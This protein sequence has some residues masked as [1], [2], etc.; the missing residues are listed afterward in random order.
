MDGFHFACSDAE[1]I[2]AQTLM[3][4]IRQHN[5]IKHVFKDVSETMDNAGLHVAVQ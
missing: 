2:A 3:S 5:G 4:L 1:E